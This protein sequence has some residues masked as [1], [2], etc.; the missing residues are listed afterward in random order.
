MIATFVAGAYTS[1]YQPAGSSATSLGLT[2]E[3]YRLRWSYQTDDIDKTDAYGSTLIESFY[4]GANVSIGG[5][6]KEYTTTTVKAVTAY[7]PLA[8]TGVSTFDLGVI[9]R[10]ATNV[11]G[12]LILTAT[13]GTPAAASPASLTAAMAIIPKGFSVEPL[14][15]P[16]HRKMPFL[17]QIY[18]TT[19]SS[20]TRF[21]S[22]T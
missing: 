18:P 12:P 13:A 16:T 21:F 2:E 15:G 17:F 10:A 1:T 19:I 14:L 3:G 6:F 5:I 9:A 4:Q 20:A 8:A 22:T 7:T 11:G